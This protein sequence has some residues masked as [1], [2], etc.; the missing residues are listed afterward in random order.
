MFPHLF[1]PLVLGPLTI[2]NRIVS[3]GHDTVMTEEGLVSDQLVNYQEARARGGVGLIV[4]QATGIN[5]ASR[6]TSHVLMADTDDATPGLARL[7]R[8]IRAHGAT[9]FIQLF[10]GG[11]EIMDA[12]DGTMPV[13]LAPSAVPNE[14][15]HVMP[16]AMSILEIEQVV[17]DYGT[18]ARRVIDAG[19]QGVEIVA[20]HGYLPSQFL[21]PHVNVRDDRYGGSR[22]NRVRFLNEVLARVDEAVGSENVVGLR[23]S[24]GEES[25]DGLTV[26]EGLE[27]LAQLTARYDYLSVVQGTSATL[28]GSDHIVPPMS[29]EAGYTVPA[30]VRAKQVVSVPVIVAGRITRPFEAERILA[31]GEADAVGMNRALICDPEMPNKAQTGRTEETRWCIG[32]NQACIG[33]FHSGHPISCIQYPETGREHWVKVR[34]ASP[35]SVVVV[36][37]GPGG[38]KAAAVAA[39]RGHR[40][41][42]LEA[43]T[44][45]GGQI[46]EAE[47]LPG[48]AEFGGAAINLEAEARRFGVD[49]RLGV[50]ADIESIRALAPEV[51]VV[52]TGS[53]PRTP[54][55][56]LRDPMPVLTSSQVLAGEMPPAGRVVVA[57]WRCDWVGLGVS[58]LLAQNGQKVVLAVTGYHPGQRIQQYARDVMIAQATRLNV[59]FR[60]LLRVVG[61]DDTSVYLQHVLTDETV[62][63][64]G[65]VGLVT[66]LGRDSN[67][68]LSTALSGHEVH[69]IGDAL[70][71]RTAEEAVLD[72][73][74]VGL[75]I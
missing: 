37:G 9:A 13:A 40:V 3:T 17:E 38:L 56:E 20:S 29:F 58:I 44:K 7:A 2:R 61:A 52:A 60:P 34:A 14:R 33:H 59:E 45:L 42:L 30:A 21:N 27:L 54:P 75:A 73:L 1:S 15:F 25:A 74:K 16:R 11:R 12:L 63:V 4:V 48:R 18:T 22:A 50:I 64:E 67:D 62:E 19:F 26:E 24:L 43:R 57:D 49:I 70:A 65:C 41:T 55:L 23:F 53:R 32:C 66:A 39:E 71:P 28:S 31:Q 5:N 35:R 69:V 47:K 8:T 68:E 10:H 51:V 72:G 6:Y 46:L 36:G